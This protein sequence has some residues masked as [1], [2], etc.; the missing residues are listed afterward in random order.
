[1]K[2]KSENDINPINNMKNRHKTIKHYI[3]RGKHIEMIKV[4]HQ[5]NLKIKF[6]EIRSLTYGEN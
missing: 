1:M 3:I 2:K 4:C 6:M 5:F